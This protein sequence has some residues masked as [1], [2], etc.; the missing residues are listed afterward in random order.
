M[1]PG[2]ALTAHL[3]RAQFLFDTHRLADAERE[4]RE[5]LALDPSHR[6]LLHLLTRTLIGQK[7]NAEA[8]DSVNSL[9]GLAPDW[10]DAHLLNTHVLLQTGQAQAAY[11]AARET[12]RI[13]PRSAAAYQNFA[14]ACLAGKRY[15]DALIAAESGLALNPVHQGCANAR[16]LALSKLGRNIEGRAATAENLS[17]HPDN[18]VAHR[19]AG[20]VN[21]AAGDYQAAEENFMAALRLNPLDKN[22][23]AGLAQALARGQ[24]GAT[25]TVSQP[26]NPS[27]H[28]TDRATGRI[29]VADRPKLP[30][31]ESMVGVVRLKPSAIKERSG[32]MPAP[33]RRS[34][35]CRF[36]LTWRRWLRRQCSR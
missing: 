32:F 25:T 1:K 36:L 13:A 23:R 34:A 28:R 3:A 15:Q 29:Q 20:W 16:A 22:A 10:E 7:K 33:R 19:T 35:L 26:Q 21:L 14:S 24:P 8:L 6:H 31:I 18:H 30:S 12:L 17:R 4:A 9:L 11:P 27:I 2:D 5:G